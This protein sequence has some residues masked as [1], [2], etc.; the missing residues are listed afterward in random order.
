MR[1]DR[2]DA[3]TARGA[4][5][6]LRRPA[7]LV[8][9]LGRR[10]AGDEGGGMVFRPS[11]VPERGSPGAAAAN[12]ATLDAKPSVWFMLAGEIGQVLGIAGRE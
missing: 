7:H 6:S 9:L 5:E 8:K 2:V 4:I 11:L 10:R 3:T 1:V 12:L